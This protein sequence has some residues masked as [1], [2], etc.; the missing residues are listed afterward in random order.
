MYCLAGV[1]FSQRC[2]TDLTAEFLQ[3]MTAL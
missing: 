3:I 1:L 2:E